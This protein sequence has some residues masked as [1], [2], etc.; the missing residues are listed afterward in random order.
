MDTQSYRLR[1]ARFEE[2]GQIASQHLK[3]QLSF[4]GRWL[5]MSGLGY[6]KKGNRSHHQL[7]ASK[8]EGG[9]PNRGV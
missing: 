8:H 3:I 2:V 7:F 1:T 4:L 5:S 6:R 9:L